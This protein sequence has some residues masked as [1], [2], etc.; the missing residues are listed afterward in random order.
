ML[1]LSCSSSTLSGCNSILS[2]QI[3]ESP[4]VGDIEGDGNIEI[5]VGT[6]LGTI[7]LLEGKTGRPREG[8][9]YP[10]SM[11]SIHGR[12]AMHD[13]NGDGYLDVIAN[14]LNGNLA[15]FDHQVALVSST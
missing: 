9:H 12:V 14:D 15:V 4:S 11:D 10:I 7:Y 3:F 5:V 1:F 6:A 8:G 13:V 2:A